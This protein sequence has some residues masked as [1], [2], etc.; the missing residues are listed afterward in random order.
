MCN[1]EKEYEVLLLMIVGI[2]MEN[3]PFMSMTIYLGICGKEWTK[4][5]YNSN[6]FLNSKYLSDSF[7][8][9]T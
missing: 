1:Q 4:S 5:R 8:S 6:K 3:P 9:S 7:A 2:K